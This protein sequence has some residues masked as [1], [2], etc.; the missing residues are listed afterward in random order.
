MDI[1]MNSGRKLKPREFQITKWPLLGV[2]LMWLLGGM[3][4]TVPQKAE[5]CVGLCCVHCG[6]NMPLNI[7]GG[8]IPEP[9]E[10]RFK[11][12]QMFMNMGPLRTNTTNIN[13]QSLLG[14]PITTP[15]KFAAAPTSMDMWMTMIG[16]AYSFSDDFALMAM[17]SLKS[18]KMPYQPESI[19]VYQDVK[20]CDLPCIYH[21]LIH[22]PRLILV[23]LDEQE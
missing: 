23:D 16:G 13:T 2:A 7:M 15:G 8:G 18:N 21:F 20:E 9:K 10:F 4:M 3:W 6:G 1:T 12:S 5:A 22:M 17:F 14:N 19:V 11:V